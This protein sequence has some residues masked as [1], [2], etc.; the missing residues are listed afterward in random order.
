VKTTITGLTALTTDQ[1]RVSLTDKGPW[2]Q[3]VPMCFPTVEL[4][5]VA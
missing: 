3:V 4:W 1:F 5:A 2:S